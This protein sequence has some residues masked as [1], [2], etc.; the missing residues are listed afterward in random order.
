MK[1]KGYIIELNPT[2][3]YN[4]LPATFRYYPEDATDGEEY[5]AETL[6]QCKTEIDELI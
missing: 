5:W 3:Y 1:Y 6:E 4:H 2:N